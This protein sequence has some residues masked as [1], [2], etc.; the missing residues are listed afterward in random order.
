MLSRKAKYGLKAVIHLAEAYGRSPVLISTLAAE[1]RIPQKFLEQILLELKKQGVLRSKSGK[2]G[3][4][5][6]SRS[7]HDVTFGQVIRSLD[8]ALGEYWADESGGTSFETADLTDRA[9]AMVMTDVRNA[10]SS[11]LDHITIQTALQRSRN[12]ALESAD[13]YQI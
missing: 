4:Y 2:G 9:I 1:Q 7:P 8:G 13:A 3:G 10:V 5:S 12:A 6:L 11:V